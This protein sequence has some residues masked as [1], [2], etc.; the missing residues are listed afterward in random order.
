MY[1][2]A[3]IEE[4]ITLHYCIDVYI[5]EKTFVESATRGQITPNVKNGKNNCHHSFKNNHTTGKCQKECIVE[6]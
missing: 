2:L 1:Y 6:E 3:L 5:T 4:C